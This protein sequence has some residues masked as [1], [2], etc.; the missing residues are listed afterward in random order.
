MMIKAIL[1]MGACSL[2]AF[3]AQAAVFQP[4]VIYGE[5]N[6]ADLYQVESAA[7]REV[8][9]S[10]VAMIPLDRL[11]IDSE[12]GKVAV[13]TKHFGN[14][15]GLCKDE[16]YFSQP[17]AA[18]CSGFLV[19]EDLIATAGHC[20]QAANCDENAFVFGFKM[21]DSQTAPSEVPSENV[22][23]CKRVVA[24]ELTR[25]QDYAL[26]QVDR[27]VKG[28]RILSLAKDGVQK[29]DGVTVIGHPSGLPTKVSGGAKVR[30]N[31]E[32]FFVANLDTYGGNSGSA[33]FNSATL[34][35]V[36]ILVRGEQ[37]FRYDSEQGCTR[38]NVCENDSCRGED[39]THISYIS[40][41]LHAAEPPLPDNPS[42]P[43]TPSVPNHVR[44]IEN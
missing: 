31:D 15:Y 3:A 4:K 9:D 10:T 43:S 35:V 14:E 18:M 36:G 5:D 16:P 20:I 39:V 33:V 26:V 7:L 2:V 8:A 32:G 19:G 29:D 41:A 22:Y 12:A 37:D 38:S 17:T 24:R 30:R 1:S 13:K 6:R 44:T 11:Q 27:P 34:D 25:Q 42:N 28:H 23:K 21:T 40:A